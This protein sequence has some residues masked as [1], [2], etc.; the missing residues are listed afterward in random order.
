MLGLGVIAAPVI[1]PLAAKAVTGLTKMIKPDPKY[2]SIT[3]EGIMASLRDISNQPSDRELVIW[4]GRDGMK[5]FDEALVEYHKNQEHKIM[6][7][8]RTHRRRMK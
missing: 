1:I 8:N 6:Y 5:A 7:G 3:S 2:H 4:T